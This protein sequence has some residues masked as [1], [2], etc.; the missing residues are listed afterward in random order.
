[1][2]SH[3]IQQINNHHSMYAN[4][5]ESQAINIDELFIYYGIIYQHQQ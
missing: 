2:V 5:D 1:M 3:Y 4:C